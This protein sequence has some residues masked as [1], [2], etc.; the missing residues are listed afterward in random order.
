MN[1]NVLV[2][3]VGPSIHNKHYSKEYYLLQSI[4][5]TNR[6]YFFDAYA[7]RVLDKPPEENVAAYELAPGSSLTKFRIALFNKVY[8]K[9]RS[10]QYDVYHHSKLS[11]RSFN[12]VI[13]AGL[14]S[15][16]PTVVGPVQQPHG[17]G[18]KSMR[19]FLSKTTGTEWS[20]EIVDNTYP[21][22]NIFRK[23]FN[24][25][26]EP[27]FGKTLE[28]ADRVIVVNKATAELYSE[29]V[30][31]SRIEVVPYGVNTNRFSVGNPTETTDI[32]A[33]GVH[34]E[35]K[36]FGPLLEAWS[37]IHQDY[38]ES[39]LQ[40]Y[41]DGPLKSELE[42]KVQNLEIDGSVNFNGHVD[43]E[44]IRKQLA[45]ARAFVHPS[46]S[47]GFPHVRLEAMSS[48]CPVIASNIRGTSEMVRDGIDGLVVPTNS[49]SPLAAALKTVL[50]NPERAREMGA[51]ARQHAVTKYDWEKIGKKM[52][53]IYDDIQ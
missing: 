23:T 16:T 32:V 18:P 25:L 11:Y 35:R 29:F 7:Q 10:G 14:A 30:P 15:K 47:E 17:I 2:A 49:V 50:S 20:Q 52:I 24:H 9:L 42:Q 4:A 27:L 1:R 6:E 51:N 37:N 28:R 22:L 3:P 38:P 13:A 40:I 19:N 36:G 8:Q 48:G 5:R 45:R 41:G 31:T 26:R 46:L 12:P 34:I 43:H 33:I 39:T 53:K 44:E 21:I